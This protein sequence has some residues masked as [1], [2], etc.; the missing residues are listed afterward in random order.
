MQKDIQIVT[1]CTCSGS[2]AARYQDK[3]YGQFQRVHTPINK[4]RGDKCGGS[5]HRCTVCGK[6]K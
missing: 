3:E 4:N 1:T 5:Q 6:E 2:D